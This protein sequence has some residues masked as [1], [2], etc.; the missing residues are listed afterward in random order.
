M[1]LSMEE[2]NN[3]RPPADYFKLRMH[4]SFYITNIMSAIDLMT[5]R[6]KNSFLDEF[7]KDTTEK[8]NVTI[9]SIKYL[10]ELRN[11]IIHRG[12]DVAKEGEVIDGIVCIIAPTSVQDRNGTK[13]YYAPHRALRDILIHCEIHTK[14]TMEN[15]LKPLIDNVCSMSP[16]TR[17]SNTLNM[18]DESPHMPDWVRKAA[19]NIINSEILTDTQTYQI[20]KLRILLKPPTCFRKN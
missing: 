6:Y 3:F 9:E 17:F 16:E 4:Y 1:K 10:R 20:E 13:N 19:R 7:N 11:S 15:L 12:F 18:I 14:L 2:I 5:D 8:N